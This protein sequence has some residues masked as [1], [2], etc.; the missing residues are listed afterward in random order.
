M[1]DDEHLVD[2]KYG[3]EDLVD[4]VELRRTFQRFYEATGFTIGFLDHPGLNVLIA[5]GWRDI[6]TKMHRSCPI[7]EENCLRSNHHLLD[8]LDTPGNLV[9]E[10]C[11]NGLVDCAFPIIIKGKHIASLATGQLL[12]HEPDLDRFRR[13]AR[14]FGFDEDT[15]M[16][17]LAEIP[18]VPEDKLRSVTT[19]LGEM[20]MLLSQVGYAQL[21]A[22][23]DAE[24]L[25][26][27]ITARKETEHALDTEREK[28]LIT[29]RS[30]GDGVITTDM[31]G[32][33]VL[34][35]KVAEELTGWSFA[36]SVGHPLTEV[37]RIVDEQTRE[38]CENPVLK[39]LATGQIAGLPNQTILVHADGTE[40]AIADISAPILDNEDSLIGVVL[41]FRDVTQKQ[42]SERVLQNTQRLESLGVLA[43]GIAHDFNN[44]LMGIM[45]HAELALDELPL[46]SPT[47]ESLSE[48][49]VASQRAAELCGQML[50][51]AG[52][53]RFVKQDVSLQD[54]IE[55]ILYM[56]K[57]CISK[58]ATLNLNLEK[59]L[60][61]MYGD[62]SQIRQI[63]MNLVINASEALGDQSGVIAISTGTM[64]CSEEHF[65]N[66][67]IIASGKPGIYVYIEVSDTGCG[68]DEKTLERI[69]DPFFTTK[70]TGRGLGLSAVIGLVN[71]HEGALRVYS[72][73][74]RGTVFKVLFP[75]VEAS[76]QREAEDVARDTW[77]G[78][79]TVLLV[80]D[81]DTVRAVSSKQLRRL[82]F[83]VLTA[84]DGQQA[85]DMY[86]ERRADIALILL[87]L[88]MPHMNG[89]EAY[90]ELR[91]IDPDV[92]II[93]VSGYSETDIA[94]RFA[95]MGLA[96]CLQKPYTLAK[97]RALLASLM[98]EAKSPEESED[99][100]F[101]NKAFDGDEE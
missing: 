6:C 101:P 76:K 19:F 31:E 79:G 53:G 47:R 7:A 56:L 93:L 41:V 73:L 21:K 36:Q 2:G 81:E 30:I 5:T 57:T 40:R 10:K 71:S 17:A 100:V 60:P 43:G 59:S 72:K 96:G 69:F 20:A 83:D 42:E 39:V 9:I 62:P 34:I 32:N 98:P 44:I 8:N 67:Y 33:I 68:M 84:E 58:K 1:H 29:L 12:L 24:R 51:Y 75:A 86:R 48:I 78:G 92:R 52:K 88:T 50:A 13:Q 70:F 64:D 49:M 74:G 87:D 18:V 22:K 15:Y 97:L 45:G 27:E 99:N 89:E 35:N 54:V 63:L 77:R 85:I 38:S 90:R 55:E 3:I 61:F 65:A 23:E 66:G 25:E 82:G 11:D 28:L 95:G 16:N 26:R 46:L 37:F 91:R 14:E 80:D 4:I 94:A